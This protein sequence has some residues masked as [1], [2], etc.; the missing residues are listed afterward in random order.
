MA[1][2]LFILTFVALLGSGLIA[3]LFFAFSSFVM[4]GLS[5]LPPEEGISAMQ[6]INAA[7]YNPLFMI[8]FVGTGAVSLFLI[9][10]SVFN[11]ESPFALYLLSA[12][13]LYAV[14]S[15]GVTGAVNVPLNKSIAAVDP[16]SPAGVQAWLHYLLRWVFWNHVRT[17][18]SLLACAGFVFALLAM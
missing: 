15:V 8:A 10:V 1:S 7:V 18:C 17:F 4:K 14:G 11:S 6:S 9:G 3:G 5:N 2:W 12:G 13:L 16:K